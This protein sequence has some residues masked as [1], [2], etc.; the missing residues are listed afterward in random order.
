MPSP[1]PLLLLYQLLVIRLCHVTKSI[2]VVVRFFEIMF[3]AHYFLKLKFVLKR[4][5]L[6]WNCFFN[7]RPFKMIDLLRKS[8][9]DI[10]ESINADVERLYIT[11]AGSERRGMP[12]LKPNVCCC[13]DRLLRPRDIS[14]I[15][16]DDLRS[17]SKSLRCVRNN[18]DNLLIQNYRYNGKGKKSFM[19]TLLMSPRSCFVKGRIGDDVNIDSFV[20]CI[21]CSRSIRKG[22]VPKFSISN[23]LVGSAPDVLMCLSDIEMAYISPVRVFGHL[24][25]AFG[26]SNAKMRGYHTFMKVD[27]EQVY[28][29]THMIDH[30]VDGNS[31]SVVLSGFFTKRQ[32]EITMT[33]YSINLDR[34][35]AALAWLRV[36]NVHYREISEFDIEQMP[37][38]VINI[39]DNSTEVES[40]D[41]N[42]EV[43][44][45]FRVAFPDGYLNE[46][47]GGNKKVSE[48]KELIRELE[49]NG[50][51][52]SVFSRCLNQVCP[53]YSGN[54]LTAAFPRVFP[55]GI[56]GPD[57]VRF[58]K[59]GCIDDNC[60]SLQEYIKHVS[61]L[62][63]NSVNESLFS[64]VMFNINVKQ[65]LVRN[66][67]W[68]SRRNIDLTSA[69]SELNGTDVVNAV[70][71]ENYQREPSL[72]A[73][74]HLLSSVELI[75]RFLPH[76]AGAAKQA[77][78]NIEALCHSYDRPG[79]QKFLPELLR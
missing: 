60:I 50:Y 69:V 7:L 43:V 19:K 74:N 32:K 14:Y 3:G 13:C 77:R 39:H 66:A 47:S 6:L 75:S 61:Q 55:Y 34:V 2:V 73:A 25:A 15:S 38:P 68:V 56:G 30:I 31:I 78:G 4:L 16:V 10:V 76:G 12:V 59:D 79:H 22:R 70:E 67:G 62:S 44:E 9:N 20:C 54:F 48:F 72:S 42:T 37:D 1:L 65:C 26:G 35:K 8:T 46:K 21:M 29:H 28:N 11:E 33:R 52:L 57:D 5:I 51:D 24:F 36:H 45:S 40:E 64:L 23:F 41:S 17:N 58:D 49:V 63:H 71:C 18:V 27:V 53:D